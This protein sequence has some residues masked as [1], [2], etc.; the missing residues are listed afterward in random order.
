MTTI[1]FSAH[2]NVKVFITHCGGLGTQEAMYHGT[3][4]VGL[5]IFGDQPK[6]GKN[7]VAAGLGQSLQWEELSVKGLY[8]TIEEVISNPE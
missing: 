8:D 5:P 2:P 1:P 7:F 4:M 6:N 3:P